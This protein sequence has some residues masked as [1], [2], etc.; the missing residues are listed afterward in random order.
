RLSV[1]TADGGT[2]HDRRAASTTMLDRDAAT[3]T[4][5]LRPTAS[6]RSMVPAARPPPP[7]PPGPPPRTMARYALSIERRWNWRAS[8]ACASA[9]LAKTTAPEV[10]LSIRCAGITVSP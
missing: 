8:E 3:R 5:F 10:T 6:G 4:R 7:A 1:N 2:D 9:V